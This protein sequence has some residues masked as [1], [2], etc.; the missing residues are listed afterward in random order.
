MIEPASKISAKNE[1]QNWMV[2]II[3][4][5]IWGGSFILIKKGLIHFTPLQVGAMRIAISAIAF[6]PIFF[7]FKAPFPKGKVLL[8]SLVVL[9]GNGVPAVL[10]ALAETRLGSAVTGVL[11]SLTPI[12]ALLIGVFF[13]RTPFKKHYLIGLLLGCIGIVILMISEKDWHVSS[14]VFFVVLGTLCYGLSANLVKH[15]CQ[16]IH[17]V[18]LT[19]VGFFPVGCLSIII[20]W[21][22]GA[23]DKLQLAETWRISMPSLIILS[24]VCTVFA[25]ILFYWII[26]RTSAIFGSAIAYA[27]PCMA[28]VW[29]S[30]DGEII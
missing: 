21:L 18:A 30:V 7:I 1:W 13:F 29:G 23:G 9:T 11:N 12:F 5:F 4:A 14:Y 8:V 27:I 6:I 15:Y 2:F 26:Q 25:N 28:L 24:L 20:L 22:T 17:P 19:A 3:L 10:F 16:D